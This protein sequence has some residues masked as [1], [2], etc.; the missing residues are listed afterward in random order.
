MIKT[1]FLI[2][3]PRLVQGVLD[4]DTLVFVQ[5]LASAWDFQIDQSQ[6]GETY[7]P[8]QLFPNQPIDEG[9]ATGVS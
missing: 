6:T 9:F 8:A 3:S 1:L 2:Q 7:F 4:G 5:F